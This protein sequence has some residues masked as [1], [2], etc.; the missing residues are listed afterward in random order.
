MGGPDRETQFEVFVRRVSGIFGAVGAAILLLMLVIVTANVLFRYGFDDPV[1]W[2]DQVT[3]YG[4]VYVTFLGAPVVL[5]HRGHVSVDVVHAMV[6]PIRG[7][8][9]RVAVDVVGGLYCCAFTF[10]AIK[11]VARTIERGSQF[12]DAFVVA[13]WAVLWVI[14]LAGALLTLQF[15]ANCYS[16]LRQLRALQGSRTGEA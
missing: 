13:Q 12:A 14:P 11:E 6:A 8:R 4:L 15:I 2:A 7:Q 10:L 3:A 16:D 1:S 5:A 9:I